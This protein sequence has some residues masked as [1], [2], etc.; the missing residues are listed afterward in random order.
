MK[1]IHNI[2]INLYLAKEA[3]KD[4]YILNQWRGINIDYGNIYPVGTILTDPNKG[5]QLS[6]TSL[7][8][9]YDIIYF[10]SSKY[11]TAR[12]IQHLST[13]IL[14]RFIYIKDEKGNVVEVFIIEYIDLPFISS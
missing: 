7:I 4:Y 5:L 14:K 2:K 9:D 6:I 8:E 3:I 10:N 1:Q 11:L 12:L 13:A